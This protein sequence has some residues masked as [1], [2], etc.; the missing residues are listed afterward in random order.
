M[1][2]WPNKEIIY[3]T[4]IQTHSDKFYKKCKAGLV[5]E[6]ECLERDLG[7]LLSVKHRI[8]RTKY[9]RNNTTAPVNKAEIDSFKI[10]IKEIP[11][12]NYLIDTKGNLNKEKD[13]F[14]TFE[15]LSIKPKL[16]A[17]KLLFS[18]FAY[19]LIIITFFLNAYH[20]FE[21]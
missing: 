3:N 13:N 21:F 9:Q 4:E 5:L 20:Y 10:N 6:R 16:T 17:R 19:I 2:N 1:L 12:Y 8:K 15:S 18:K 11:F 7:L 14:E